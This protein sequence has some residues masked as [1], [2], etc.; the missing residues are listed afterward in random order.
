M[1]LLYLSSRSCSFFSSSQMSKRLSLFSKRSMSKLSIRTSGRLVWFHFAKITLCSDI[2]FRPLEKSADP[3][4]L[5]VQPCG[6]IN[7]PAHQ[8]I[9]FQIFLLSDSYN[10]QHTQSLGK[11][12]RPHRN[13]HTHIKCVSAGSFLW[14]YF[15]HNFLQLRSS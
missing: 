5:F 15:P 11:R 2:P 3:K 13:R 8:H 10:P 12:H 6:S 1:F 14:V 7:T 4:E 9:E